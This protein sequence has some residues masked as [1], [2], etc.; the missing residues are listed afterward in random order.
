M[1]LVARR[2]L[3]AASSHFPAVKPLLL[4][5]FILKW[6]RDIHDSIHANYRTAHTS[7]LRLCC[8]IFALRCQQQPLRVSNPHGYSDVAAE[9]QGKSSSVNISVVSDRSSLG[10]PGMSSFVCTVQ[11]R[12]SLFCGG[13]GGGM[14]VVVG[15]ATDEV[16]ARCRQPCPPRRS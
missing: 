11:L 3:H 9:S 15:C 12:V 5:N 7:A 14:V 1:A 2:L 16:A 4:R 10:H 6:H 8:R 13:S